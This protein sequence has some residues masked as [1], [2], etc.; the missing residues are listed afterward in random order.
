MTVFAGAAKLRNGSVYAGFSNELLT[1]AYLLRKYG[2][3][4]LAQRYGRAKLIRH[5]YALGLLMECRQF[6]KNAH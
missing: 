2:A 1:A 6:C 4:K 5:W 3:D